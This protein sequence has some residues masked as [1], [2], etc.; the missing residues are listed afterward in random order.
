[1]FSSFRG[2]LQAGLFCFCNV[3]RCLECVFLLCAV[4]D[5]TGQDVTVS[6]FFAAILGDKSGIEGGSGKVVDSGPNDHIFIYYTDHGGPGVL[7]MPTSNNL[8]AVDFVETLKK[9]HESGTYKEMVI[10]VEACESGSIF[11]GLLPEGLNIYVTTASN[12]QESSWG[13]YCPG[14]WPA[15]PPEFYTCLGDLY[16]VAWMEDVE[17]QNLKKETLEDQYVIVKA[18]TSNHETYRT[19]SHVMQYGDIN[20]DVEEMER[21]LGF[22]PANENVTKPVLPGVNLASTLMAGKESA[23]NQRDADLLH[24]WHKYHKAVEGS[25]RKSKAG[26][27]LVNTMAHRMHLDSS[28]ELIGNLLFGTDVGAS[29]LNAVRPAG[30]VLVDDWDCLKSMVR[31]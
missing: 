22:D 3:L 21:Y 25:T 30:Q 26:E 27:E 24:L 31:L 7:G 4:Q 19:G 13:T 15:P 17:I 5:Y 23:V 20:I 11:E 16:S 6:N 1:M 29:K 10:Y 14:M 9:K 2:S 8:Y 12:A 28:V 18:R